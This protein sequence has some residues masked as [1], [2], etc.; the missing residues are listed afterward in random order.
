[1]DLDLSGL[2]L[3]KIQK[4]FDCSGDNLMLKKLQKA[5]EYALV[6]LPI[7]LQVIDALKRNPPTP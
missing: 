4:P 1:M 3:K 5:F 2:K 6:V 7:A